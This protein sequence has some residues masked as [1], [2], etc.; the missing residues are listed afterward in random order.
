[1]LVTRSIDGAGSAVGTLYR[2]VERHDEISTNPAPAL[3][4]REAIKLNQLGIVDSS[5]CST[6]RTEDQLH[7]TIV[8]RQAPEAGTSTCGRIGAWRSTATLRIGMS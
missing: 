6:V 1:M 4:R 7:P 8:A 5:G 2:S 3:R